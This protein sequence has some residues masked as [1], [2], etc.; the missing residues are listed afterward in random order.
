MA[1]QQE[2][3]SKVVQDCHNMILWFIPKLDQFPRQRKF[4]LGQRI[5]T[6]LKNLGHPT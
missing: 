5:E 1:E 4:T 2:T 6:A 3:V